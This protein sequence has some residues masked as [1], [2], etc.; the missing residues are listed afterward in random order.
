MPSLQRTTRMVF[1]ALCVAILSL[2]AAS[3]TSF[4][5]N[6]AHAN[7]GFDNLLESVVK[8][9]VW[10]RSQ[11]NG[12]NHIVRSVG[13]GVIMK[14]DGTILTNAHVV[15][16]YAFKI[17][18][19][20]PNLERVRAHFIGWDHWTDLALIKLDEEDLKARSLKFKTAQFGDSD[21]LKAGNVVYAVGTPHG[22][23]RTVT[24]GIVSN[25]SRFFEGTI[26]DS[27]YETGNFNTWIQTD[28]AIN[29]GNSGGPLVTPD[30]KVVGINTRAYTNSNNLGFSVP[31]NVA[32]KIM[33]GLSKD[34]TIVRSYI[35]ISPAPLQDMEKFF[36]VDMNKGML[37]RNVDK[38]SPAANAGI[39]PGD[40]VLSINGTDVDGRFP[41]QL[42]AIMNMLSEIEIGKQ[43]E[44][45]ISRNSKVFTKKLTC[46]KLESRVGL[47][48]T[49]DKW[50]VGMR[51]ITKVFAREAKIDADSNLMV[52][53]VRDGYPFGMAKIERGDII[54]A[55]NRKKISN[56]Q[57]LKSAYE[58]YLKNP[59]K[60]L[61]E[62]NRDGV[63]SFHMLPELKN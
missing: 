45:L 3:C 14:D 61:V 9:D 13:S 12:G 60:T 42:P 5:P 47:E 54:T 58:E 28:A 4:S 22:F 10:E 17:I 24:R 1:T 48:Y 50:G 27:G 15:N 20:L 63:I 19:T 38:G 6:S 59:K 16:S 40:I 57:E 34:K 32:K 43:I 39:L 55:I 52:I 56:T 30:G 21:K 46:E 26:L 11:E 49:L 7:A 51:E 44:L 35:G 8:I 62:V 2:S 31:S 41:E 23:A 53:G 29:P 37:V 36:D 33:E 25:T 18:V